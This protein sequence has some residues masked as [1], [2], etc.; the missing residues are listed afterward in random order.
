MQVAVSGFPLQGKRLVLAHS[1][2]VDVVTLANACVD[3]V[4]EVDT[5]PDKKRFPKKELV[6][7][8]FNEFYKT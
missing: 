5:F 2:D 6:D 7:W 3:I 1:P 4:V 8:C